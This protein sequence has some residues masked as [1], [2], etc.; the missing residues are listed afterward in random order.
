PLDGAEVGGADVADDPDDISGLDGPLG[1]EKNACQEVPDE[2]LRAEPERQAEHGGARED[3]RDVDVHGV[4]HQDE[5][6]EDDGVSEEPLDDG[7]NP[8]G[9]LRGAPG[10][11]VAKEGM[12]NAERHPARE[13]DDRE[14]HQRLDGARDQLR[15]GD[16]PGDPSKGFERVH[17]SGP[18]WSVERRGQRAPVAARPAAPTSARRR[19]YSGTV[20]IGGRP[21]SRISRRPAYSPARG[22]ITPASSGKKRLSS[23]RAVS[24][25]TRPP[26]D[27]AQRPPSRMGRR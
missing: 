15:I 3:G 20:M 11:R 5:R 24:S 17:V 25:V 22:W 18:P 14:P 6:R 23:G 10:R 21:R 27:S 1:D 19:R 7:R 12:R 4:E 2:V 16:V 9:R 8:A 13:R 26:P